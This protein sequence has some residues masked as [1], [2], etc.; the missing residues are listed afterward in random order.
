MFSTPMLPSFA[1]NRRW[2]SFKDCL[3]YNSLISF[4]FVPNITKQPNIV[5]KAEYFTTH[6]F[7]TW[8]QNALKTGG[9]AS[10]REIYALSRP[11]LGF[12]FL[13]RKFS[14]LIP[15]SIFLYLTIGRFI[16][17]TCEL[18]AESY[19]KAQIYW[20]RPYTWKRVIFIL[21]GRR[22]I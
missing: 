22:N 8:P 19:S 16:E 21:R 15:A 4:V 3:E 2:K 9:A 12:L 7:Y 20:T 1:S 18:R 14:N 11:I 17:Y 5:K 6:N 10:T 13:G